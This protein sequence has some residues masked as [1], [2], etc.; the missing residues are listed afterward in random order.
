[1]SFFPGKDPNLGDAPSS[2]AIEQVIVPRSVDLG[3]FQ[4]HRALPSGRSRMVG[5]FIFFDHFGP[6]VFKAG[7]G[8]DVRP[9]PHIGLATVTYLFDGEIVHRDSLGTAMPIRPGAVN[10]MTAGRGIV[11]SERTAAD[12]RDGGEPLHGLQLWVALPMQDEETAPAFAHTAAADIPALSEN[13]HDAARGRRHAARPALAGRD[14]VGHPV[15]RGP[16]QRRRHAAARRRPRRARRLCARRRDRDRR[17]PP[18]AGTAV[19]AQAGRQVAIRAASD[20]HFVV[21]GGA[22]MDGPRHIW[23]NFVS[24]RKERIEAAK[25]DWKAGRFDIVPGDTTEFIPLPD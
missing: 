19:G 5:P 12:H 15:R 3:G 25:A 7:D 11:H 20:A 13:G 17:R 23:W 6:A 14:L 8:V 4:V 24:S 21:V 22:A 9:H 10:W 1:M 2:D 16:P 18:R